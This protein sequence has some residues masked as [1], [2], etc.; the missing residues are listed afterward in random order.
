[1][2]FA[3]GNFV[4]VIR[5]INSCWSFPN[6]VSYLGRWSWLFKGLYCYKASH[7]LVMIIKLICIWM[8]VAIQIFASQRYVFVD[9]L[10][11]E[12]QTITQRT[13][14]IKKL[15]ILINVNWCAN[16]AIDV[17][18]YQTGTVDDYKFI[19]QKKICS[20]IKSN[21]FTYWHWFFY[22]IDTHAVCQHVHHFTFLPFT[23][24]SNFISLFE[25]RSFWQVNIFPFIF[26]AVCSH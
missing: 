13:S 4:W 10:W 24:E 7:R 21:N 19:L 25:K 18:V 17:K 15:F 16:K 6:Q 2:K 1:M 5:N 9:C 12:P 3:V 11:S 26:V 23:L 8:K 20:I 22:W 14:I